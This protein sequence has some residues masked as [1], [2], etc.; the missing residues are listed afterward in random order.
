VHLLRKGC[1]GN[2]CVLAEF[3]TLHCPCL[4]HAADFQE[5]ERWMT[6]AP[7]GALTPGAITKQVSSSLVSN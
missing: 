6:Q 5:L 4:L 7:H 3:V 2:C 1:T